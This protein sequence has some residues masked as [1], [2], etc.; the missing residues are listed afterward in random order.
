MTITRFMLGVVLG[1]VIAGQ[2]VAAPDLRLDQG[3]HARSSA[4]N[5]AEPALEGYSPVSYFEEGEPERGKARFSSRYDG[6]L[7]YFTSAQQ[8]RRFDQ[9]PEAYAPVFPKHCPWNLAKG[10]EVA[11]DPTNYKIVNGKLLLFHKSPEQ[12]GRKLWNREIRK[13]DVTEAQLME[14]AR[15]NLLDLSF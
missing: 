5:G 1:F 6:E 3:N 8:K 12:D 13:D 14:K 11:V 2:A 4:G 10:R 9:D 7:Y 15:S